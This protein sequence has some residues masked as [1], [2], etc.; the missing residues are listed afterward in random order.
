MKATVI[1][2]AILDNLPSASGVEII[3]GIIY[4]MGDDSPFLYC[5]DHSLKILEQI[6]L[7]PSDDFSTGR[8]SKK[9]KPDLECITP[10][11]INNNKYLLLMGSG[12]AENRDKGFLVKLPTKYNK[13][14]VVTPVSFKG[15]YDLLRSNPDVVGNSILNLEAAATTD[16]HVVLFNR[17]NKAGQNAVMYFNL[18]EF[19]VY[20]TENNELIPFPSIY[21]FELPSIEG[22]PAGFSGA[23]VMGDK[24]FFTAACEDTDDPVADGKVTGSMIGWLEVQ[25][26]DPLRGGNKIPL[27][28]VKEVATIMEEG[29]VYEGKVE[30]ISLHEKDSD[31]EYIAIAVTDNDLGGSEILMVEILLD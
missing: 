20:L 26:V 5:L 16:Q 21:H 6:E 14:H 29:K 2:R 31:K 28:S 13:K 17:A 24:L 10:L 27:S 30:S 12:S 7:F 9:I 15:L 19:I 4:V 22:V 8:I 11:V 18:E 23:S 1:K 3:E 25:V